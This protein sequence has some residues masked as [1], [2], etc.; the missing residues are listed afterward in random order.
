MSDI[1]AVLKQSFS[2][3]GIDPKEFG[4]VLGNAMSLIGCDIDCQNRRR[5]AKLK[6]TWKSKEAVERDAPFATSKAERNY[7]VAKGG[8]SAYKKM[9]MERYTKVADKKRLEALNKHRDFMKELRALSDDYAS[10]E[11]VYNRLLELLEIRKRE[12][13]E[14]KE[15]I[16]GD[17]AAVQTNDRRVVYE[18]W[19]KGWL[20]TVRKALFV[21]Y[22]LVVIA[23]LVV[24][25]FIKESGYRTVKGWIPIVLIILFPLLLAQIAI[26]LRGVNRA[27]KALWTSKLVKNVYL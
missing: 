2:N 12:N 24:G 4:N 18:D 21:L 15:A 10:E 6:E 26:F 9:L 8:E 1:S 27:S 19:A 7:Y 16:D 11:Q 3:V 22:I 23:Y 14:L 17:I 25:P 13:K 20:L 5:L